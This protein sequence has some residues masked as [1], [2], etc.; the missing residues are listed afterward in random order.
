MASHGSARILSAVVEHG[1]VWAVVVNLVLGYSTLLKVR[2]IP[3]DTKN[4]CS[5]S[6]HNVKATH[7][8]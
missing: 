2:A 3:F 6:T 4:V 5:N 7:L 1:K 8:S